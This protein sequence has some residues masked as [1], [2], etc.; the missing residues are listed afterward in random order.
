MYSS[1]LKIL[2]EKKSFYRYR[3]F[4]KDHTVTK[5]VLGILKGMDE[6]FD[7]NPS[8]DSIPWDMFITWYK[9]VKVGGSA[10]KDKHEILDKIFEHVEEELE[11]ED[12]APVIESFLEKDYATQMADICLRVADGDDS[13]SVYDIEPLL[14]AFKE[15]SCAVE[16]GDQ[17]VVTGDLEE[18]IVSSGKNIADWRLE[19][20][21]LSIGPLREEGFIV[22][23][24]APDA[25]KTTMLASEV[26][27]IAEQLPE[28]QEII[29]FNNEEGG[30]K[31]RRR[32]LQALIGWTNEQM[33]DDPVG[34]VKE[35][36]AKI[37]NPDRIVVYNR[38]LMTTHEI[39]QF[40]EHRNPGLIVFDQ[41]WKVQGFERSTFSEAQ[42]ISK[43]FNWGRWVAS[44]YAPVI[45]VH[46]ADATAQGE[47]YIE[48]H[49]LYMSKVA[50]QGEMDAIIT[51]GRVYDP[52]YM[53]TRFLNIA[54]NKFDPAGRMDPKERNGKFE[55]E[56]DPFTARFKGAY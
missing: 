37:G 44:E 53:Y 51:L 55:L 36:K 19:E 13:K 6:Y 46:Q 25:G 14:K 50:V 42:A 47:Q 18:L 34:A 8:I 1:L 21:N 38:K 24:A 7:A 11:D 16:N 4:I 12:V 29:W 54:K 48:Q 27:F 35:I 30:K 43:I 15:E 3:P 2:E 45:T 40:L 41:L 32:I 26:S 28:E 52:A 22:F 20:L 31:V 17:Y 9:L 23:A 49:Q 5:E 33:E 56:I 10:S 39:E